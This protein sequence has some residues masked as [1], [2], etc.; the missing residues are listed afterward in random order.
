MSLKGMTI[1][2]LT[3]MLATIFKNLIGLLRKSGKYTQIGAAMCITK[4]VQTSPVE[5]I[6]EVSED[7]MTRLIEIL[8]ESGCKARLQI[9][10][11]LLSI[12]LATEDNPERLKQNCELLLPVAIEGLENPDWNYR[13]LSIEIIYTFNSIATE[14]VNSR[15]ADFLE[16]LNELRF[17]KV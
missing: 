2:S 7:I 6:F 4:I 5:C 12:T 10:E 13:K 1:R 16:T 9:M 8:K 11:A 3:E 17:D 14:L 15:K